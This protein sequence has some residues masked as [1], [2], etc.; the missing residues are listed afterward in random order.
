M[1]PIILYN[2]YILIKL[3]KKKKSY[4]E[5]PFISMK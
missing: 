1:K 3:F 4:S 2:K 5:I